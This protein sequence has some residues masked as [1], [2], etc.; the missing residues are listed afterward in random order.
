MKSETRKV[1]KAKSRHADVALNHSTPSKLFK[2]E[3]KDLEDLWIC[4]DWL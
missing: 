1:K 4:Q 2:W 3:C